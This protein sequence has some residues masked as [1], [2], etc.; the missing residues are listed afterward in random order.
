MEDEVSSAPT[1]VE[2]AVAAARRKSRKARA[3]QMTRVLRVEIGTVV[4]RTSRPPSMRKGDEPPTPTLAPFTDTPAFL[5]EIEIRDKETGKRRKELPKKPFT[6]LDRILHLVQYKIRI[7]GNNACHLMHAQAHLPLVEPQPVLDA[8]GNPIPGPKG[9]PLEKR[10]PVPGVSRHTFDT[11]AYQSITSSWPATTGIPNLSAR[12]G[13][14]LAQKISKMFTRW[15][16]N[17]KSTAIPAVDA[18]WPIPI[19]TDAWCITREDG[20]NLAFNLDG[21]WWEVGLRA[22]KKNRKGPADKFVFANLRKIAVGEVHRGKATAVP[23]KSMYLP[24]D[25]MLQFRRKKWY[26]L[27]CYRQPKP[28]T[29]TAPDHLVVHC[30]L[31]NFVTAATLDEIERGRRILQIDGIDLIEKKRVFR[32]RN[33]ELQRSRQ[34]VKPG[35]GHRAMH[36]KLSLDDKGRAWTDAWLRR[37]AGRV[38][39]RAKAAN[40]TVHLM[41]LA[42][43]RTRAQNNSDLPDEVKVRTHQAPWFKF[44]LYVKEGCEK[45]GLPVV[46]Y[47][48]RYHTMRCPHCQTIDRHSVNYRKWLFDCIMC[49][50]RKNI[51]RVAIENAFLDMKLLDSAAI[52]KDWADREDRH[53]QTRAAGHKAARQPAEPR[54][55]I[56]R[57]NTAEKEKKKRRP[58]DH[59]EASRS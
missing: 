44:A 28:P 55:T 36:A 20:R 8:N 58:N 59:G 22:R 35:H 37:V 3:E 2:T 7:V 41:E 40:A 6:A 23:T 29:R 46:T 26:A 24:G 21:T 31:K 53:E 17:N 54:G 39:R 56:V 33:R 47:K 18:H 9:K 57:P 25:L 45:L 34:L 43:I 27:I 4:S 13:S 11:I 42:N 32:L 1:R 14:A 15:M 48:A 51:E 16:S 38:V 19:R 30:G 12:N 5:P 52:D 49:G 10:I 50:Y